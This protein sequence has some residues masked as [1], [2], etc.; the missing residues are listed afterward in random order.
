[1]SITAFKTARHL[2]LSWYRSIQ[3]TPPHPTSWRSILILSSHLCLGI[4]NG[5]F[6]SGFP[7]KTPYASLLCPNTCYTPSPS[8]PSGFD[9][10]KNTGW[11]V[12]IIRLLFMQFSPL[13]QLFRPSKA[14]ILP[15]SQ[16]PSAYVPPSMWVTS[17]TPIQ[18]TVLSILNLYIFEQQSVRPQILYRMTASIPWLQSALNF[19]LNRILICYGCSRMSELFHPFEGFITHPAAS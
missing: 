13:P 3:S 7:T 14:Q 6:S 18:T 4:P 5:L 12:Q 10:P 9:H 8:H 16:T 19:F 2:S 15:F 1:M 11:A 17:F